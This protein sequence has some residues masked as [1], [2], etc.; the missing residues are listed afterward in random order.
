MS[1]GASNIVQ[2]SEKNGVKQFVFMSGF[3]QSY[4]SELLFIS[5]LFMPLFRLIYNE[6]YN[7]KVIAEAA[8]QNSNLE[9]IISFRFKQ[10]PANSKI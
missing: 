4:Y 3:V 5:N 10:S 7:D 8:I 6:S 1:V 9:W 2:A